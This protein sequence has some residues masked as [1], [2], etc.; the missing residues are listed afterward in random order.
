MSFND[1]FDAAH[2]AVA[3]ATIYPAPS[4]QD[5]I[6]SQVQDDAADSVNN[7]DVASSEPEAK[8]KSRRP[9]SASQHPSA[10]SAVI[11]VLTTSRYCVSTATFEGLAVR[12]TYTYCDS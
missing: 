1:Q 5:A 8:Q 2:P 4:A 7:Q 10:A 11:K 9:A 3:A 12:S 6:M